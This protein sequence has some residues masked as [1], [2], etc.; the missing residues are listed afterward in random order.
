MDAAGADGSLTVVREEI[1]SH[2]GSVRHPSSGVDR[3]H[4]LTFM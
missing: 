2:G 3:T 4:R 1:P